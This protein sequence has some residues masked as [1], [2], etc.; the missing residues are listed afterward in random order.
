MTGV[1]GMRKS[2][3]PPSPHTH[4]HTHPPGKGYRVSRALCQVVLWIFGHYI[5]GIF[6]AQILTSTCLKVELV[7]G[8]SCDDVEHD[9]EGCQ[10]KHAVANKVMVELCK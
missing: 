7:E 3:P 6:K 9:D 1:P 10:Y 2:P 5:A 4:T 8:S